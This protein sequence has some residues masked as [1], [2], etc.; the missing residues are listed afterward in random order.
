[1]PLEANDDALIGTVLE[2]RFQIESVLGEGGMGRVYLAEELRLRRRC[3]VK[4][5]LPDL[6]QDHECVE[7]DVARGHGAALDRLTTDPKPQPIVDRHAAGGVFSGHDFGVRSCCSSTRC[8]KSAPLLG[9][10]YSRIIGGDR[11]R[12]SDASATSAATREAGRRGRSSESG[13]S[14]DFLAR[15]IGFA[16]REGFHFSE[17]LGT[18]LEVEAARPLS[19]T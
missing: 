8:A 1:M 11:D 19:F 12:A 3:A 4:V 15:S 7:L 14:P 6:A 17:L 5:L 2:G 9:L 10:G 18:S 16:D 13:P